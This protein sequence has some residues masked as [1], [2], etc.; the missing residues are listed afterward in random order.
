MASITTLSFKLGRTRGLPLRF[1]RGT[2]RQQE[3]TSSRFPASWAASSSTEKN[4]AET[5]SRLSGSAAAEE[6]EEAALGL[7]LLQ[8]ARRTEGEATTFWRRPWNL[9]WLQWERTSAL[10]SGLVRG[11]DGLWTGGG[12]AVERWRLGGL[13]SRTTAER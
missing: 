12:V 2:A 5:V 7:R 11:F 3:S 1:I 4:S 6:E 13:I 10:R 9:P 8:A